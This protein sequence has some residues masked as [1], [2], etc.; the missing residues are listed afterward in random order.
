MS[1]TEKLFNE[2][3]EESD[4]KPEP[5]KIKKLKPV[6]TTIRLEPK[7]NIEVNVYCAERNMR[8]N[9]LVQLALK[10]YMKKHK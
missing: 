9:T 2:I 10:E 3:L 8:K 5:K 6:V 4:V 7:F 1:D